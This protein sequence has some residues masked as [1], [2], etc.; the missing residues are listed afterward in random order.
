MANKKTL[1]G[2]MLAIFLLVLPA[3]YGNGL[4]ISLKRTN[5]GIVGVK[6][7]ELIFDIVNTDTEHKLTGFILCRSPDDVQISSTL[8]LSS[9]SGAQYISPIFELDVAPSQKAVYFTVE[10]NYPGDYAANCIF[11]YIP[12]RL[13]DGNKRYLK[14]NLEETVAIKESDYR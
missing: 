12:Y 3:V 14:M 4:S 2:V 7:A 1:L 5:P 8:G 13:L 6:P 11:E 10:S 9:G